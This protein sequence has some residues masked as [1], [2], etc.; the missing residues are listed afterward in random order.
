MANAKQVRNSF[1]QITMFNYESIN[2]TVGNLMLSQ[3]VSFSS[4]IVIFSEKK[5]SH[6]RL[7]I[8]SSELSNIRAMLDEGRSMSHHRVGDGQIK[9][10]VTAKS[11]FPGFVYERPGGRRGWS[12]AGFVIAIFQGME[13]TYLLRQLIKQLLSGT[14]ANEMAERVAYCRR[15]LI[16]ENVRVDLAEDF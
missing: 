16:I 10:N 3:F 4:V 6:A 11:F 12:V 5:S 8:A 1:S 13:M 2:V 15:L 7:L 9:I 14:A